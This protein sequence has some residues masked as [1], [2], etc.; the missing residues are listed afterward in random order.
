M[1]DFQALF[2]VFFSMLLK[3]SVYATCA[4]DEVNTKFELIYQYEYA[5]K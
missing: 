2:I 3:N 5:F 1:F 4:I